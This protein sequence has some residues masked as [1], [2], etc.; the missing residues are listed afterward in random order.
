MKIEQK[1]AEMGWPLHETQKP[2][3]VY[4]PALRV[5]DMVYT[6]GQGVRR[7]GGKDIRGKLGR[8]V[9]IEDGYLAARYCILNCLSAIK[10]VIGDLDK[11]ERIVKVLGFVNSAAGFD[12]QPKV[13][14]GASELLAEVFGENGVGARSAIG[15][16]ELPNGTAVEIEIIVKVKD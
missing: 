10:G 2:A 15:V 7:E 1:L 3:G 8:E 13:I 14:N 9:S 12:Q 4:V 11:I 16:N 6:S 5:G